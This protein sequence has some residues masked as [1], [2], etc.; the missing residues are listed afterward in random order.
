MASVAYWYQN[1]PHKSFPA[2]EPSKQRIPPT[3][4]R[5][6]D[7]HRWRDAWRKMMGSGATLWGTEQKK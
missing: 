7:M 2:I 4:V 1:E 3:E 6:R 5:E